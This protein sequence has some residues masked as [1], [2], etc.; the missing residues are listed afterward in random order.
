MSRI[1]YK[2]VEHNGG[3]AY[4]VDG[5]FFET[6]SSHDAARAAGLRAARE[7]AQP[8]DNTGI[9]YEDASGKWHEEVADGDDRPQVDVEG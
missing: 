1:V 4:T 8:G 9:I 7:Q 5:S 3:W 6:F 2:I